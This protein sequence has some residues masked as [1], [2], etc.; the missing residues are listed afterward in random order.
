MANGTSLAEFLLMTV[1]MFGGAGFLMGQALAQT[2][3]PWW[4]AMPYSA[5]M[6]AANRFLAYA[7]FGGDLRSVGLFV[8]DFAVVAGL[9][10]LAYRITRARTM[11][12]QYPWLYEPDGL[13][14]WRT[15]DASAG[16][17][18]AGSQDR[19]GHR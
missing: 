16:P 8:L 9:A 6:A 12:R 3:R 7:L 10:M 11:T 19:R 18:A 1:V 14:G 15:R 2:W 4:H 13:F 17:P 5:L